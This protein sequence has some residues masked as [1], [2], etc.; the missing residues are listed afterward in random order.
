MCRSAA[1]LQP[2]V[3]D[4]EG[5][6]VPLRG[7]RGRLLHDEDAV[8]RAVVARCP[9]VVPVGGVEGRH[10]DP[11]PEGVPGVEQGPHLGEA[12]VGERAVELAGERL[13]QGHPPP[14]AQGPSARSQE[15]RLVSDHDRKVVAAAR[16][17]RAVVAG[18]RIRAS[19]TAAGMAA[20]RSSDWRGDTGPGYPG[21]VTP[22]PDPDSTR[23][24]APDASAM[25]RQEAH[26]G[27]LA[28]RLNWLRAGVLGANDGIVSTAGLVVGVAGATSERTPVLVAGIAGLVAGALSMAAGE[29]VSVST[30]R[31]SE[32]AMLALEAEELERMPQTE[33]RELA[34]IYERK[35]L[36]RDLARRVAQELTEHD[37]LA[38]HAEAEFGIDKD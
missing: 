20:W 17:R 11:G 24:P 8:V 35:G 13:H 37:A 25:H 15:A 4:D 32:R 23:D 36:S 26:T 29:Y 34:Q 16:A 9:A 22:R 14:T 21:H 1:V 6:V 10:V 31:D 38:A 18:S 30:Q 19:T 12:G 3:P 33:L 28:S 2:Q 5:G 7:V 27:G